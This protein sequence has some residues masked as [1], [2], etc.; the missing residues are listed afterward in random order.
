MP[1]LKRY[2][3]T[4]TLEIPEADRIISDAINAD[5]VQMI[6]LRRR[7]HSVLA[8]AIILRIECVLASNET[9]VLWRRGY[10]LSATPHAL[11]TLPALWTNLRSLLSVQNISGS[12]SA[13]K[14]ISGGS[15]GSSTNND[16][17]GNVLIN[18]DFVRKFVWVVGTG[19]SSL[20]RELRGEFRSG[21][22]SQSVLY[23]SESQVTAVNSALETAL[24]ASGV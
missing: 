20:L 7:P 10:D 21:L 8:T 5:C 6:T 12:P 15:S 2:E 23:V 17:V 18:S 1:W 22:L 16:N 11:D 13:G 24:S 4:A 19:T 14:W 9:V 3:D